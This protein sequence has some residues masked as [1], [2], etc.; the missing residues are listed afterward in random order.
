M[1]IKGLRSLKF[2]FRDAL[3]SNKFISLKALTWIYLTI[4]NLL[5]K[6]LLNEVRQTFPDLHQISLSYKN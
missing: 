6:W 1:S 2:G 5:G 4:R 3:N